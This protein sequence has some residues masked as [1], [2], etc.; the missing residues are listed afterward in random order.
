TAENVL[1]AS[2]SNCLA[3]SLMILPKDSEVII[4]DPYYPPYK[5]LIKILGLKL[6]IIKTKK[7]FSLNLE[8]LKG[9]VSKKTS[10]IIVNNPNNPTGKIYSRLEIKELMNISKERDILLISDEIY[11]QFDYK[12]IFV[13]LLKKKLNCIVINSFSKAYG[14]SGWRIGYCIAEKKIIDELKKI[15][16]YISVCAPTP[17]Q[18]AFEQISNMDNKIILEFKKK[19]DYA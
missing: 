19:R 5:Q 14:A 15:H 7:D 4:F 12:K 3:Y 11:E 2:A 10:A 17:F 6:K 16:L 1:V 9:N 13:S 8:K 18:K